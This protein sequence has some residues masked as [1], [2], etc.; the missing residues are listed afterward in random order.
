MIDIRRARELLDQAYR[1]Q[2]ELVKADVE[3]V[4][5]K[6]ERVTASRLRHL[7]RYDM[8]RIYKS[9]LR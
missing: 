8:A 1:L 9:I 3:L 5:L 2:G 7:I 4:A 6:L